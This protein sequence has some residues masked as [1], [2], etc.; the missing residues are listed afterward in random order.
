LLLGSLAF[1][2]G[3]AGR[4]YIALP[5]WAAVATDPTVRDPPKDEPV[6]SSHSKKRRDETSEEEEEEDDDDSEEEEDG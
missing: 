1:M 4:G 3:H 2:V 6:R 5:E